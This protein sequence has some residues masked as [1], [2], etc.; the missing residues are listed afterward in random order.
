MV[1]DN[2]FPRFSKKSHNPTE[3]ITPAS[4]TIDVSSNE[5]WHTL[6]PDYQCVVSEPFVPTSINQ[7]KPLNMLRLALI[8]FI[9][10]VVAALFGFG[11]I[12]AGAAGI[13]KI[14]FYIFL[15]LLVISLLSGALRKV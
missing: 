9:V 8:F 15:V 12:A 1:P 7:K 11:G 2:F 5:I 4:G 10:A 6:T 14:V 13:A 3:Q